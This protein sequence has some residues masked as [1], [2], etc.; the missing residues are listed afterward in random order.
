MPV[1]RLFARSL[2]FKGIHAFLIHLPYYGQRRPDDF[3]LDGSRFLS[4][5]RQAI[6]DVRR[7]RDAISALPDI[8]PQH[9]SVQGTSLGGFV[10]ATSASLDGCFDGTFITLAGGD[11]HGVITGG[12]KDTAKVR[13]L[14]AEAGFTD[15]R[16][17]DLLWHIEPNRVA[18]RLNPRTTWLY[19]AKHDH[20]VPLRN[21]FTL[22]DAA[23][24]DASHHIRVIGNH[25]TAI[26]F[27]PTVLDHMVHSIQTLA[28][29]VQPE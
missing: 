27:F 25:Y 8:E 22:A 19:S 17:K 10:V 1:G 2:C 9:I 16:L 12:Q 11:L 14:L 29:V 21:A 18:H 3:Q 28:G 5:M 6:A 4:T 20:V 13:Q 26:L 24:L 7:A 15:Q 23:R